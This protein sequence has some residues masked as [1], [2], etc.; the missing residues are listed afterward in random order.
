M[1][2]VI[3]SLLRTK[4][5]IHPTVV[6]DFRFLFLLLFPSSNS[7]SL[8]SHTREFFFQSRIIRELRIPSLSSPLRDLHDLTTDQGFG[9]GIDWYQWML[10]YNSSNTRDNGREEMGKWRIVWKF[11]FVTGRGGGERC[12]SD[13]VANDVRRE[14][15][16]GGRRRD[17]AGGR[18]GSREEGAASGSNVARQRLGGNWVNQLGVYFRCS[19]LSAH[20]PTHA[21][22]PFLPKKEGKRKKESISPFAPR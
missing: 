7:I 10:S 17:V 21:I 2:L 8:P 4:R 6:S 16:E 3:A 11:C 20:L 13:R 19:Y 14:G 12:S 9:M 22:L 18:G 5:I 15:E 1:Y